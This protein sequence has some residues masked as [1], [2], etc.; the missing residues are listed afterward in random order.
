MVTGLLHLH[1]MMR[2]VIL[3]LLVITIIKALIGRSNTS[4]DFNSQAKLGLFTMI[5]LHIQLL[6]G[7]GLLATGHWAEYTVEGLKNFI[8]MEHT[9]MMIIA[10]ILG[11]L[12]HSLSK[13][14][15]DISAKYKKQLIFFS[16][17]LVIIIAMIPWP[18]MRNFSEV[19]GWF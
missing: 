6:V 19:Y 7:I 2:W 4:G 13:R 1:S 18:C 15:E 17:S 11:T 9:S 12:G 8:M 14:A 3:A 16:L 10:V 5:S